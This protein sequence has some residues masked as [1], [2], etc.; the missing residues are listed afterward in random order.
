MFKREIYMIGSKG[1]YID[2]LRSKIA[3]FPEDM[4]QLEK[5]WYVYSSL[6][7]EIVKDIPKIYFFTPASKRVAIYK[8]LRRRILKRSYELEG[9]VSLADNVGSVLLCFSKDYAKV[10]MAD[11]RR[12]ERKRKYPRGKIVGKLYEL[13]FLGAMAGIMYLQHDVFGP[14]QYIAIGLV[15]ALL[16][17]T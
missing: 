2:Y 10:E 6:A 15:F 3:L 8:S 16:W 7:E 5:N 9:G 4:A 12:R 14:A 1:E 11:L 17:F 13:F